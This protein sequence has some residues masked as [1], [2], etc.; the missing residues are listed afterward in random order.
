MNKKIFTRIFNV[1]LF[2]EKK[3]LKHKL[4]YPL[5]EVDDCIY[6]SHKE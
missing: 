4:N 1:T 3:K 5:L 2:I 6:N